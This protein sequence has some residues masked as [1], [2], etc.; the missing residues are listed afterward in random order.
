M[1]RDKALVEKMLRAIE[2][3]PRG[4]RLQDLRQFEGQGYAS[5]TLEFHL[6]LL[7]EA[8]FIKS[9]EA[10]SAAN[11]R[12]QNVASI[13]KTQPIRLTWQG[14]EFLDAI[15]AAQ[16]NARAG[17]ES[18]G[19]YALKPEPKKK[20]A[21]PEK[22][23]W[24]GQPAWGYYTGSYILAAL[25]I[26][27][28]VP[29]FTFIW[30]PFDRSSRKFT[31]TNRRVKSKVGVFNQ[32]TNE[33]L[34]QDIRLLNVKHGFFERFFGL[35]TIEIGSAGTGQIEVMLI[36]IKEAKRVRDLVDR[37]RDLLSDDKRDL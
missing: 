6:E 16:S 5:E 25:A 20:K 35:G 36:G 11:D 1:K 7:W 12:T 24:E 30:V 19:L 33:V 21:E 31:L 26:F 22:V 3:T 13:D 9:I 28:I 17:G 23:L 8:Q 27:L 15:D 14:Y 37:H 32:T 4:M 29:I 2:A 34:L 10:Q 18:A